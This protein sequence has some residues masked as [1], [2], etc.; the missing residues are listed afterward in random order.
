MPKVDQIRV[1]DFTDS[2][3]NT[4]AT[5]APMPTARSNLALAAADN[6]KALRRRKLWRA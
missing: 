5:K 3:S 6:G 1:I 4:R 2:E